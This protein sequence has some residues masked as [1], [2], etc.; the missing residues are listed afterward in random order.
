MQREALNEPAS[1]LLMLIAVPSMLVAL[2]AWPCI[3]FFGVRA[4]RN[5]K[6]EVNVWSSETHWNP[7]NVVFYPRL[8]TDRGLQYRRRCFQAVT[9]FV[10]PILLTMGL[11][12]LT[13][14]LG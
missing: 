7:L 9:C 10:V 13:G 14:N 8:L 11:A 1:I 2:V 12:A 4:A 6:A 3:I 5:A